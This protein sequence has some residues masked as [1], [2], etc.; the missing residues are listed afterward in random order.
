MMTGMPPEQTIKKDWKQGLNYVDL[1]GWNNWIRIHPAVR[2]RFSTNAHRAVTYTGVMNEVHLS[3]VGKI[4]AHL[5][6]LIGTP[7]A[8]YQGKDVPMEV[9]VYPNEKL[10]G[11]TWERFYQYED[12][13]VNRVN[14]TKCILPKEL[15]G[16][17]GLVEMVGCGFGM[18]L[19][20]REEEG[21]IVFESEYFFWQLG[22]NKIR[23]PDWLTPGKTIVSQRAINDKEFE[24]RL[25]VRH[26]VLGVVFR[27]F[28]VFEE[29]V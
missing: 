6:R 18:K 29:K 9:K 19:N 24:F 5:C 15:L 26:S 14:S 1:V 12:K 3:F 27:Q 23:I 13:P 10:K 20:V 4:F 28:G 21:A 16:E 8:L 25:D 17:A 22:G 11:M 2:K 7:L